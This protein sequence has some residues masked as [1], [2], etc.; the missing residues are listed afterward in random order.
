MACIPTLIYKKGY[1]C[2]ET[3]VCDRCP[4]EEDVGRSWIRGEGV[5]E[6][7][8]N[9]LSHHQ[10]VVTTVELGFRLS[11]DVTVGYREETQGEGASLMV[12]CY[13]SLR[14]SAKKEERRQRLN[15]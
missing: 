9:A 6:G 12:G 15:L 7:S 2:A 14:G 1:M 3:G 4:S 5:Q 8:D 10:T 13:W 11:G